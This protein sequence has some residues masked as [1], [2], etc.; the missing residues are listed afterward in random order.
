M[1]AVLDIESGRIGSEVISIPEAFLITPKLDW[2]KGPTPRRDKISLPWEI[3]RF[4][5]VLDERLIHETDEAAFVLQYLENHFETGHLGRYNRGWNGGETIAFKKMF[6][7]WDKIDQR[8][9][10][11][12]QYLVNGPIAYSAGL[13]EPL[14]LEHFP[15]SRPNRNL[16]FA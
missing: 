15:T 8:A 14:V 2:Q 16:H 12:N 10:L 5:K 13:P 9:I 7:T 6:H 3:P 4:V 1:A 11:V